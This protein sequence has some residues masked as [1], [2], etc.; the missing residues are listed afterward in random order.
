MRVGSIAALL[1]ALIFCP[2]AHAVTCAV[3]PPYTPGEAEMAFLHGDYDRAAS[4]YQARLDEHPDNPALVAALNAALVQ[5]YLKQ[6]KVSEASDLVHKALAVNASSAFLLTALGEVQYRQGEPWNAIES[7]KKAIAVNPCY[8]QA[9][10]LTARLLWMDSMNASAQ[11]E[12]NIAHQ[13]DSY[14]PQIRTYWLETLPLDDRIAVLDSYMKTSAEGSET[15]RVLHM[16]LDKLHR[17]RDE[18]AKSCRLVSGNDRATVN[19]EPIADAARRIRSFGLDVKFNGHKSRLEIDTGA[20]G[21]VIAS[22]VAKRAGLT[23]VSRNQIGGVGSQAS[24]GGYVAYADDIRIGGLEFRDCKV[25]VIDQLNIA[26]IDGLIGTN[27]FSN[28]LV[29]LDY[30]MRKLMLEPLPPRPGEAASS[31]PGLQTEEASE[32]SASDSSPAI[33]SSKAAQQS[34][35]PGGPHDRYIAPA[36]KAWT[37]IYSVRHHLLIP[38]RLNGSDP[39]LF[40]IDTGGFTTVVSPEAAG[41]VSKLTQDNVMSVQGLNGKVDKVFRA[42]EINFQFSHLSQKIPDAVTFDTSHISNV[43]GMEISGLL[44]ATTLFH[45]VINLDYRDGLVEFTYDPNHGRH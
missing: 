25:E 36:M 44:G 8:A 17:L 15:N 20:N 14:D 2:A 23:V 35:A 41:A 22:D 28:F 34:T 43:E 39:R 18:P 16:E 33:E 24:Q 5:V 6:Q 12:I 26:N 1:L 11:A 32:R 40:V 27:V 37:P 30:P 31:A 4:L 29:T 10:L 7:A 21:L 38:V 9:H 42:D 45:L 13:I 19:F 3:Q